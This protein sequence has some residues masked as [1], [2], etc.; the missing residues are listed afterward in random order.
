[1]KNPPGPVKLVLTG[2]CHLKGLKPTRIK[3]PESGK[4][5]DDFWPAAGKMIS[6]M[7]FLQS[8]QS[9]DKDNIPAAV[10]QKIATYTPKEDFQPDRVE[11]VSKA[12]WGLCMWVRA[13]EVYDRVAKVVAPKKETL[14][15]AEAEYE[16][17]MKDLNQKR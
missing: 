1:M 16:V 15:E 6:E 12:A 14:A 11:R 3:D 2:V 10:V 4:M 9:F 7:G 17:V 8:L 5:V 13:M